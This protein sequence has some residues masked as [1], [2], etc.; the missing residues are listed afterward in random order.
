MPADDIFASIVTEV[1]SI[2]ILV[3]ADCI[4]TTIVATVI[5]IDIY[6]IMNGNGVATIIA[7]VIVI[8]VFM[9]AEGTRATTITEMITVIICVISH[10]FSAEI[11]IVI[12]VIIAVTADDI[13]TTIVA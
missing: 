12:K 10:I 4:F 6:T 8:A 11:A 7:Q 2:D 5:T 1:I 13:V 9:V 3:N